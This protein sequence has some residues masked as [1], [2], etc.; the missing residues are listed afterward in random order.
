MEVYVVYTWHLHVVLT[1]SKRGYST[2]WVPSIKPNWQP[3]CATIGDELGGIHKTKLATFLC[4]NWRSETNPYMLNLHKKPRHL[5]AGQPCEFAMKLTNF[6]RAQDLFK[7]LV[8]WSYTVHTIS[9]HCSPDAKFPAITRDHALIVVTRYHCSS[10]NHPK[11]QTVSASS[12]PHSRIS[13]FKV[14]EEFARLPLLPR[15]PFRPSIPIQ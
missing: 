15:R 1:R 6:F 8:L 10:E 11:T 14:S 3:F 7:Q 2:N 12:Q 4:C 9:I 13:S 5:H